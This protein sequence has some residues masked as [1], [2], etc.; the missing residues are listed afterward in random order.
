MRV[1]VVGPYW[2]GGWTESVS[3]AL[4]QL[5]CEVEVFYYTKTAT[6]GA[7]KNVTSLLR[8]EPP[9]FMR[10]I[11][12]FMLMSREID[13]NLIKA[14]VTFQPD[15]IVVLKGEVI[16]PKTLAKLKKISSNPVLVNWW[17]DNPVYQ[18][19]KHK[20]LIFPYCVPRYDQ[21]FLFDYAYFEPLKRLGAKKISFLPCAADPAQYHP[22]DLTAQQSLSL[23][24]SIC[25]IATYYRARGDL[26]APF[27]DIPG[28][29][30]WG[31]GWSEFLENAGIKDIDKVVRG[32]Y[33][34]IEDVN[35]AYQTATVVIN[36]HHPQTKQAGLNSRAFEIPASGGVQLTD[37][38]PGMEEL[39]KPGE[40]VVVY[41]S[42]EEGA[43]LA[44]ELINDPD[45]RN[46]IAWA[47]YERVMSE[48]T[49]V[50]RM[51]T[52]LDNI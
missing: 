32:K 12:W 27:L 23:Q 4:K 45:T 49:Y 52:I 42:P 38:V 8:I 3:S 15:L 33:L 48:H 26:I 19:E 29:A 44:K 24:C 2:F 39:L 25:F 36:S 22:E 21:I 11:F 47:G 6:G 37:Y 41:R 20:W 13:G 51:R 1:L 18:D 10:Q 30:L 40:E 46:K 43:A 34:P 31:G 5:N 35:R 16:L 28:F 50:H 17:V 7:A 9:L 14:A